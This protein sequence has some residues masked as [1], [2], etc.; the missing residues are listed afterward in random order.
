MELLLK[1]FHLEK[2]PDAKTL[3]ILRSG[4]SDSYLISERPVYSAPFCMNFNHNIDTSKFD[5]TC[6]KQEFYDY[7]DEFEV[8]IKI[9]RKVK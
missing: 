1:Q 8:D 2:F 7:M 4:I 9:K 5:A 6:E 3:C